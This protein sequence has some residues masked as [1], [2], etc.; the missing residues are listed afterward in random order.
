[1][2]SVDYESQIQPIFDSNCG[3]CHLG[4]SS[5]G[6]NL[7]NY[8]NLMSTD[9]VT[10]GDHTVSILY[11]RITRDNADTGDM[12]PGNSELSDEQIDLIAQWIDEGALPEESNDVI[13]CTDSNA[14]NY[15]CL[16]GNLPQD[17]SNGCGEN[18]IVDDGTCIY[19]PDGFEY[20]QSFASSFRWICVLSSF[21]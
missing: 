3:N 13:G 12:P 11:D 17:I 10:P 19:T 1:M 5:G 14:F 2:F 15:D 6:L 18:V 9:V 21:S 4:N 16:T 7:S 8:E 20:N